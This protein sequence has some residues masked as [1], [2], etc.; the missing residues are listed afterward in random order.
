L[1]EALRAKLQSVA[2]QAQQAAKLSPRSDSLLDLVDDI[3]NDLQ[4]A[5]QIINQ[6]RREEV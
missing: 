1:R 3:D 2:E 5:I 6:M 4:A